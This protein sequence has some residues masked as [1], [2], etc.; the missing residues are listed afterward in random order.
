M[1]FANWQIFYFCQSIFIG[2]VSI[3]AD[4]ESSKNRM[5]KEGANIVKGVGQGTGKLQSIGEP[6]AS[7]FNNE[8]PSNTSWSCFISPTTI[9]L[10]L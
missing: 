1:G 6:A 10:H 3:E 7:S 8:G 4:S 9:S 2:K 5:K